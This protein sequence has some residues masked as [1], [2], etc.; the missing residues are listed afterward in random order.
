MQICNGSDRITWF[1]SRECRL[2]HIVMSHNNELS[3]NKWWSARKSSTTKQYRN[4][5]PTIKVYQMSNLRQ[6]QFKYIMETWS[7]DWL[8][9][10]KESD[11]SEVRDLT[12]LLNRLG[13][14]VK[15]S[16]NLSE[17]GWRETEPKYEW[18]SKNK[19]VPPS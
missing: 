13:V 4:K 12:E 5:N 18:K 14:G 16:N 8:N 6:F 7:V 3:W 17:L 9:Q 11:P 1:N 15:L 19:F 2:K 10:P